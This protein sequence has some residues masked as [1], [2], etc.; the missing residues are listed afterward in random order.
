MSDPVVIYYDNLNSIQLEKNPIFHAQTKHIE[1]HYHFI[2]ERV[3]SGEVE[4]LYIPTDRQLVDIFTKPLDLN[5]FRH[6]S[7]I[8]GMQ[9]LDMLNW[10]TN[11]RGRHSQKKLWNRVEN[12]DVQKT[13]S[14]TEF[15][16]LKKSEHS[17]P[18]K[19]PR[20]VDMRR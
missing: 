1:V 7:S 13:E 4:M 9:H 15:D 5:K 18:L 6:F 20:Q 3:L 19:K 17:D 8:L 2:Q 10:G 16:L 14:N 12:E 11:E